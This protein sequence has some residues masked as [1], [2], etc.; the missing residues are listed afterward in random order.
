MMRQKWS[1][2]FDTSCMFAFAFLTSCGV[3]TG[4]TEDLNLREQDDIQYCAEQ[5]LAKLP[6]DTDTTIA[7]LAFDWFPASR[8]HGLEDQ[9]ANAL[10]NR[11]TPNIHIV[12]HRHVQAIL[13]QLS[14]QQSDLFDAK[15]RAQ[16]GSAVPADLLLYGCARNIA[17][18]TYVSLALL[19]VESAEIVASYSN[20]QPEELVEALEIVVKNA[21]TLSRESSIAVIGVSERGKPGKWPSK[22]RIIEY[23]T[24]LM[25]DVTRRSQKMNFA[26]ATTFHIEKILASLGFTG[27]GFYDPEKL[28]EVGKF[29]AAS[30]LLLILPS[31]HGRV[32]QLVNGETGDIEAS[33][34][35]E[36]YPKHPCLRPE[37]GTPSPFVDWLE[38]DLVPALPYLAVLLFIATMMLA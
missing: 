11:K 19:H 6:K 1:R 35:V 5:L 9:L 24:Q 27:S 33:Q 38:D 21:R 4:L 26:V 30:H 29:T 17:E 31:S 2:A 22:D 7:I 16:F 3:T 36:D 37:G 32:I 12:A 25:L 14:F 13:R 34:V 23:E 10:V 8:I 28:P 15:K 20:Y 18:Q